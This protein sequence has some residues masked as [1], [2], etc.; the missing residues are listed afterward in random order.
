[1]AVA[2]CKLSFV[3]DVF[4]Q[5]VLQLFEDIKENLAGGHPPLGSRG[6]CTPSP[7]SCLFNPI[8]KFSSS[9]PANHF[10]C[11]HLAF[12]FLRRITTKRQG[13]QAHQPHVVTGITMT[14]TVGRNTF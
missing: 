6:G 10:V 5:D 3:S 8:A 2:G 12:C 1:M 9:L 13:K 11:L 14:T 4:W 7:C